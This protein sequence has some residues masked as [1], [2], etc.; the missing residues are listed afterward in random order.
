MTLEPLR[1]LVGTWTL[2]LTHP[3]IPGGAVNGTAVIEWLEGERFLIQRLSNE[4]PQ[5][6]DSISIIGIMGRDRVDQ[7]ESDSRLRMH[8]YDSRGVFRVYDASIDDTTWKFWRDAPGFAQRFTATIAADAIVGTS[9][10]CEDGVAWHD[11]L[12]I[13]YRRG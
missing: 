5:I 11:D 6:P 1:R 13:T 2:Q 12:A 3:A 4:H 10:L 7:P 9:Q 8:Y